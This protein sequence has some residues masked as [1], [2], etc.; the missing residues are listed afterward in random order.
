[1]DALGVK[2]VVESIAPII[3]ELFTTEEERSKAKARLLELSMKGDLAQVALNKQEADHDS[4]FVAG[5]RPAVGWICV[6]ALAMSFLVFPLVQTGVV[7]YTYFTGEQVPI[8]GL[9]E[10][11][12]QTLGPI[13]LGML[14]LGGLRSFEKSKGVARK[15]LRLGPKK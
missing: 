6:L 11:D 1:M 14:G 5:W 2:G 10:L 3:D 4:L 7:Y 13:L 8:D 15:R 9:P 12:W